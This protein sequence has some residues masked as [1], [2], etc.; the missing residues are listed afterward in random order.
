M[1]TKRNHKGGR[2]GLR[3]SDSMKA[4]YAELFIEALNSME[5]H[6]YKQPWVAA[7]VGA[8]CNLYRK[9]KPYTVRAIISGSLCLSA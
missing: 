5:Q 8:P 9:G 7:T 4:K 6:D 1:A 3:M 2:K